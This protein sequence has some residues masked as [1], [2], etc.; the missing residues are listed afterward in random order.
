MA[1]FTSRVVVVAVDA[2]VVV[3]A[4]AVAVAADAVVAL[5]WADAALPGAHAA[6]AKRGHLPR[7][8]N[9][10][11]LGRVRHRRPGLSMCASGVDCS[12]YILPAHQDH[13][14]FPLH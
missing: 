2:A 11:N 8:I 12:A 3:A 1:T 10:N 13:A 9:I 6:G 7:L 4:D 14:E 5:A